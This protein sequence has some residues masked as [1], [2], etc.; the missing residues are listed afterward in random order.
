MSK[1][2]RDVVEPI[3]HATIASVLKSLT[4][5]MAHGMCGESQ[6]HT[7]AAHDALRQLIPA[8]YPTDTAQPVATPPPPEV[9]NAKTVGARKTA[10]QAAAR[11]VVA[12][13]KLVAKRSA[14]CASFTARMLRGPLPPGA[15]KDHA[16]AQRN[17]LAAKSALATCNAEFV[18]L[19]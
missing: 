17:L 13:K 2:K 4:L 3:H 16:N 18:R 5:S 15:A 19:A 14:E 8:D 7:Q 9:A 6:F 11:G 10:R 12:A 1:F